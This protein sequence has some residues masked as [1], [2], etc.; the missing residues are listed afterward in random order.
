MSSN[1]EKN[2]RW[3]FKGYLWYGTR[4]ASYRGLAFK[5]KVEGA[6]GDGA[7]D[8]PYRAIAVFADVV[9]TH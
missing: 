8:D 9:P 2:R 7:G 1:D 5:P 4:T 3:S 6:L